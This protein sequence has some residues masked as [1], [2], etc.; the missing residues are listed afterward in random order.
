LIGDNPWFHAPE[1]RWP[2]SVDLPRAEA[3][4]HAVVA[5]CG[6]AP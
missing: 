4:A 5:V 2:V 3:I 1:D 6:A